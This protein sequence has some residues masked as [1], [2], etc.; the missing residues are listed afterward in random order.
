ML[1]SIVNVRNGNAKRP[2]TPTGDRTTDSTTRTVIPL[3]C[4]KQKAVNGTI[5][6][7]AEYI[8]A[9]LS[10]SSIS[11]IDVGVTLFVVLSSPDCIQLSDMLEEGT[12]QWHLI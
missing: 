1:F 7:A 10:R 9:M 11:C 6:A 3:E 8:Q 4:A 12:L 5:V 2:Y